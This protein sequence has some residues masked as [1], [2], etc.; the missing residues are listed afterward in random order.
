MKMK[1]GVINTNFRINL[2]A[3]YILFDVNLFNTHKALP[4]LT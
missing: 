2:D 1:K 3:N 4:Y